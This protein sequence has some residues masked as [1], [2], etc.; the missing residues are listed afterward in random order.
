MAGLSDQNLSAGIC[1]V[2]SSNFCW[3]CL[4]HSLACT[5]LTV[6]HQGRACLW[7]EALGRWSCTVVVLMVSAEDQQQDRW[8]RGVILKHI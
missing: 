6:L 5:S 3:L 8:C 7:C 4:G 1:V 2:S